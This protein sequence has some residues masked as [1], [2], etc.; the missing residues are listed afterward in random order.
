VEQS[1][2]NEQFGAFYR[3]NTLFM[4]PLAPEDNYKDIFQ[5]PYLELLFHT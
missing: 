5:K 2:F 3:V 4:T 1:F